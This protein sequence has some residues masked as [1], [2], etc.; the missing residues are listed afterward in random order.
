M[1]VGSLFLQCGELVQC[2]D[3]LKPT[4]GVF[5]NI[6]CGR[7]RE[8]EHV[9]YITVNHAEIR[10]CVIHSAGCFLQKSI[11]LRLRLR[12]PFSSFWEGPSRKL[13][14]HVTHS[15]VTYRGSRTKT[16]QGTQHPYTDRK[17]NTIYY[18]SS[19]PSEELNSL[20][21]QGTKEFFSMFVRLFG[22][23]SLSL[24]WLLWLLMSVQRVVGIVHDALQFVEGSP[25]CHCHQRVRLHADHRAGPFDQLLQPVEVWLWRAPIPAH[26][27]VRENAGDHR[28]VEH[29][30][31]LPA[32][33]EGAQPP[34]E[35][36]PAL[37]L[38][39]Q[40]LDVARPLGPGVR[41]SPWTQCRF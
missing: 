25:L 23:S 32:D 15:T 38:L 30:Q 13:K 26:H 7:L 10:L 33:V 3:Q 27:S 19:P 39:I 18:R 1:L 41:K 14:L 8:P 29:L 34:Q 6:C 28:L 9:I 35:V 20:M 4:D 37:S 17:P 40:L 31:E 24:N 16:H 22:R 12:Q 36:H 2:L 11:R 5:T 21:A